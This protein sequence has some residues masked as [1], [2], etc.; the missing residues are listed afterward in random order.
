M[1]LNSVCA[2]LY[3]CILYTTKIVCYVM[4]CYV[5]LCYVMLC[6]VMLCYVMLCYYCIVCKGIG[7]RNKDFMKVKIINELILSV[8][9]VFV[10]CVKLFI[11]IIVIIC[12][13]RWT[14]VTMCE[15]TL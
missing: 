9:F 2:N 1:S 3:C 15:N 11:N 10:G 6:Y 14:R 7:H 8:A 5:M 13:I 12:I 4:L